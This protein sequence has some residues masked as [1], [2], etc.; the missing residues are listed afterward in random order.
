MAARA[1][2]RLSGGRVM[3]EL[4]VLREVFNQV[5]QLHDPI[6]VYGEC[7]HP[8]DYGCT[9]IWTGEYGGCSETVLG[10]A[11][12]E[13]C[14]DRGQPREDCPH[15]WDHTQT[16]KASACRTKDILVAASGWL[17]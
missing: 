11:C 10:W 16:S 6:P 5:G 8:D 12:R 14:Y 7:D 17:S 15:G 2:P 9:G 3:G 13:C 4:D 1:V